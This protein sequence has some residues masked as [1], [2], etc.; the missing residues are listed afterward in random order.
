MAAID[1]A[2]KL[3]ATALATIDKACFGEDFGFDAA[4][5]L[6]QSPTGAVMPVYTVILT[7]KSPLLG[8]GPLVNVT[9]IPTPDPTAEQVEQAVTKAMAGLRELSTEIL[10]GDQSRSVNPR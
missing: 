2:S 3:R 8:Q 9:Q 1:N 5:S 7:K 6:A 4:V 10:T